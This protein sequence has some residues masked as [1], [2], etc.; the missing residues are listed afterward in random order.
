MD[1]EKQIELIHRIDR[2]IAVL[3]KGHATENSPAAQVI[4]AVVPVVAIVLGSVLLFFFFLWHYRLKR[5][6]ILSGKY[7][8]TTV[9][10]LRLLSLLLGLLATCVGIP[11]S[12][13]FWAVEGAS[14]ALL[15]GLIPLFS[16]IALLI[17]YGL[18]RKHQIDISYRSRPKR[19]S[20]Q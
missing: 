15:G 7:V 16:G 9:K 13:L 11:M 1:P 4:L 6:L 19:E 10:N 17:F 18:S 20:G 2:L 3:E 14:Y 5:E 12:G 8:H